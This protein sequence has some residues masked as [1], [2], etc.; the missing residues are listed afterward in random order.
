MSDPLAIYLHD[1]LAGSS[2]AVELLKSLEQKYHGQTL[3][4][5]ARVL[6]TEVTADQETLQ[7]I[8]DN[9]GRVHLDLKE[10]VGWFTEK[11]AKLKLGEDRAS[12]GIGTFGRL[13]SM[14]ML[15][16]SF[17]SWVMQRQKRHFLELP[18]VGA[19]PYT[20]DSDYRKYV[21]WVQPRPASF[22]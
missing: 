10:A 13:V 9:V 18:D 19:D 6:E 1:H 15:E 17:K 14:L 3:A 21:R 20:A 5:F 12:G 22:A 16:H 11:A 4:D 7:K 8:I 2:F